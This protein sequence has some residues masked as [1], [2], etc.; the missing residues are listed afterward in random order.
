MK[1]PSGWEAM[2]FSDISKEQDGLGLEVS[3]PD[4][5]NALTVFR[6]DVNHTFTINTYGQEMPVVIVEAAITICREQLRE[7]EDGTPL[8]PRPRL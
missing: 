5:V 7:F 3:T 2:I 8:P 4:G 6:S 1:L